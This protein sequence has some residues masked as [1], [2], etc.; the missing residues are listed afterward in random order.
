MVKDGR[1][2]A[3]TSQGTILA[4]DPATGATLWTYRPDTPFSGNRGIGIGERAAVRRPA[5]LQRHRRLPG[6][7]APGLDLR[8]RSG[9]LPPQ[10]MSTAPAYRQRRRRRRRVARRQLPARPRDR[11]RREDGQVPL[12]LRS[13]ARTRR[14]GSRDLAAGQRHLEVRRRRHLDD[15][16][17]R[18]GAGARV[19]RDR[20]RGAPM[21]RRTQARRQPVQQLRRRARPEDGEDALALPDRA[22]RHLGTRP[23]HAARVC[24]T[25]RSVAGRARCCAAMRTDGI[26]FFLDRETGTAGAAGR[27]A[28][29]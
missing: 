21:G 29:R 8:A 5:R 15:A 3:V 14:A 4:L 1:L 10:G 26:A 17:G 23:Q 28:R 18:R 27:G 9:D 7:R 2:F 13:R 24:T 20:Q 11:A 19:S 6:D 12:D 22:P 25:R 16:V